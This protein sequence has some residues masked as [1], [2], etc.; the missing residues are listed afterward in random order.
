M[1]EKIL[2]IRNDKL[3]DFVLAL[4]SFALL[5]RALPDATIVALV[6]EYTR[7]LA[8]HID[9]IDE[10]IVDPGKSAGV[11]GFFSLLQQLRA[12]KFSA[13]ICLFSTSRIAY[14]LLLAGI[15]VRLGPATK[16]WQVFFNHRL[17]QRR[18]RSIKPE[19]EYNLDLIRHFLNDK[20][21]SQD[22][23]LK[24]PYIEL[25]DIEQADGRNTLAKLKQNALAKR[26]IMLHPGHGGSAN[27]LSIAQYAEFI[28]RLMPGEQDMVIVSAGPG[29][30]QIAEQ[31]TLILQR[32][33]IDAV[34]YHSTIGLI[35]FISVI[36]AVDL[37]IS[38]STG[39]LHV[40]GALNVKTVGFYPRTAHMSP[41][42][43]QTLNDS[44]RR[45]AFT[46]PESADE[47]AMQAIDLANAAN[48]VRQKFLN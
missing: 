3:G 4:P 17:T 10:I 28:Q 48:Q 38:G 22:I 1:K 29:E 46:P 2:V 5:K 27:N 26:K 45:L 32:H 31:L 36:A 40:A 47:T 44:E 18:S 35:E 41:L 42:R 6:P 12:E 15:P 14:L 21:V 34:T 8:S 7:K 30:L 19:F 39:P 24:G 23:A 9:Y 33:G 43:W 25:N 37:F 11:K 20:Q 16:V 13:A